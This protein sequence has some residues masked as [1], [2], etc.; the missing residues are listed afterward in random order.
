MEFRTPAFYHASTSILQPL[1][2]VLHSFLS[3]LSISE[4]E[5]LIHF[6][7]VPLALRRDIA[8]LGM[9]HRTSWA[10]TLYSTLA[11]REEE[12]DDTTGTLSMF[13]TAGN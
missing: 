9:I 4:I 10:F 11:Q 6:N 13:V 3:Q 12:T 8:M 1:D 7:L 2:R 5:A